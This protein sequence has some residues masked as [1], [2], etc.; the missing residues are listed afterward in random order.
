ML[1]EGHYQ[2][3][4]AALLRSQ[5]KLVEQILMTAVYSVEKSYGSYPFNV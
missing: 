5:T 1:A 2:R 4:K 3:L